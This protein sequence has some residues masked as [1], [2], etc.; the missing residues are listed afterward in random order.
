[1][2]L[3]TKELNLLMY[4]M[5]Y[6]EKMVTGVTRDGA[7]VQIPEGR[8]FSDEELVTALEAFKV[9]KSCESDGQFKDSE[10]EAT[11][12]VKTLWQKLTKRAWGLE[13]GETYMV[14]KPKLE[15]AIES[16]TK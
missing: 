14:L 8:K 11:T 7:S 15:K 13:D 10:V 4:S 3:T 1:M 2:Q 5:R 9:L 12:S 16:K 6:T